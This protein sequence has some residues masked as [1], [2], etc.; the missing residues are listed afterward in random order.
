MKAGLQAIITRISEDAQQYGNERY[1]QIKN[2]ID[3]EIDAENEVYHEEFNKQRE[4]LRRH[5]EH[6]CARRLEYQ[7]SRLNRDLLLYQHEL[8]DRIFDMAVEK[9]RDISTDEFTAMFKSAMKLL[10]GSYT[11]HLGERSKGKLGDNAIKDAMAET[12]GLSITLSP[13]AIAGKSGFA[14]RNDNIEFNNVFED[15]IEDVKKDKA[16]AIMKEVFGNSTDW[17]FT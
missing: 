4:I 17:M 5:N 6:E 11:L 1:L 7:R 16:A 12:E 3:S 15:L 10:K 2:T 8:I 14:L 9:L 13:N